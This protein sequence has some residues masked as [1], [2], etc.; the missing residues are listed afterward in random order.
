LESLSPRSLFAASAA[1][2]V[3]AAACGGSNGSTSGADAGGLDAT[4]SSDAAVP[5]EDASPLDAPL[6]DATPPPVGDPGPPDGGPVVD[7]SITVDPTKPLG[8]IGPGFVGLSYEKSHLEDGYF[9]GTNAPL[10]ALFQLLGPSLLRVGGN[11]VDESVWQAFDAGPPVGDA[12]APS[13]ITSADVDGLAAFA[14][15]A[16][17]KVLY[18]VNL[19]TSS[20]AAA[21]EEATYAAGALGTSLYGFEI[22]NEPDLYKAVASSPGTWNLAAF[23]SDWKTFAAAIHAGVPGAPLTGPAS[24]ADYTS[25]TVPFAKDEAADIVLLT[26]HYYVANGQL[27]TSTMNLLLAPNP[28]LATELKG[29]ATAATANGIAGGYRLSECNSFYNGGAPGVSDGYGTALWVIDFL[30]ANAQNGSSGINLHGGGNGPGYTPIADSNAAVVGARP[31]Y[32]GMLLFAK[33]GQGS[34]YTTTG[35]LTTPNFSAYAVGAS[36]AT[37]SVVLSNKDATTTVRATVD[38]GAALTSAQATRLSGPSLSATSGVTLG[39]VAIEADGGFTPNAPETLA[40][41]GSTFEVYVPPASAVLV[42]V[43]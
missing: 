16:G 21:E 8:T 33:A 27:A 19:K 43:H 30:F 34:V 10:I 11:S 39:G 14:K 36:G 32:Y 18:G 23:E 2:V 4:V 26:Q 6:D 5:Q 17:W 29:L 37:T 38:V 1:L 15:A 28:G 7:A 24:A 22:G 41:A 40:I 12:A 9:T 42:A 35:S 31:E 3:A 13:V 25:W 20:A